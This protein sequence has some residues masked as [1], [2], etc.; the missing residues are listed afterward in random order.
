MS[1]MIQTLAASGQATRSHGGRGASGHCRASS[2][3]ASRR[4]GDAK[5]IA[6]PVTGDAGAAPAARR[7]AAA[8]RALRVS[9]PLW[10]G[11]P[12]GKP[13]SGDQCAAI[14]CRH[15]ARRGAA[16][17]AD[18]TAGRGTTP[19]AC[20]AKCTGLAAGARSE[21]P[22]LAE[23][24]GRAD[25]DEQKTAPANRAEARQIAARRRK[26]PNRSCGTTIFAS[27]RP[28][29]GPDCDSKAG[30]GPALQGKWRRA[31][32]RVSPWPG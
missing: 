31:A 20:E 16:E 18:A 8:E 6:G 1:L 28:G 25:R 23:P 22:G 14:M 19:P 32:A 27:A 30:R 15:R 10:Q 3:S 29:G 26:L 12:S 7:S 13:P 11:P 9:P 5:R 4:P 2:R 17:R 21:Q 24:P